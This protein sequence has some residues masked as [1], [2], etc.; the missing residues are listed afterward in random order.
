MRFADSSSSSWRGQRLLSLTPGWPAR[1]RRRLSRP[2]FMVWLTLILLGAGLWLGQR[3]SERNGIAQLNAVAAE[4]LELYAAMLEAELARHAYLPSLIAIDEEVAA[5]L[6]APGEATLRQRASLRLARIN[7]RAGALMSFIATPQGQ[8][9]SSSQAQANVAVE[10][11]VLTQALAL[12]EAP[13]HFFAANREQ[14]STEYYLVHPVRRGE[15]LQALIVVKLDL[16]P[17]EATW[18][19]LGLRSQGEKL[20]VVDEHG[21]VI[22]SSVP[23][24]KYRVLGELDEAR[25]L[26]LETSGRY[27]GAT[28]EPI[29][30]A[31][32]VLE[33]EDSSLVA[34]PR[35]DADVG[36]RGRPRQLLAQQRAAVT[37]GVRLLA[38]SDPSEVWA[39]ARYAGWGGGAV[40][41]SVGMLAL[42]LAS[43][44][45]A[46]L[47][48]S[49]ARDELQLAQVQLE[50]VVA[51]R[52]RELRSTNE[53]LKRQIAQRIQA[54]DEL[55]QAGKLAVLGQMSTGITH[56]INQPLTA[57]RALSR[58]SLQLL[59][60]GRHASVADNL[61]MIDDVVE[62]MSRITRQLKSFARKAEV[63]YAPVSLAEAV[64]NV[65]LLMEHR[66]ESEGVR[67]R[68]EV[69]EELLVHCD[70]NR[71]E[72]VLVNLLANA[73]D[74]VKDSTERWVGIS[75]ARAGDRV[76]VRVSDTG[77]GM[78]DAA[79]AR[80]FEPFFTTK[81]PGQGL[82]LGLVISTKIVHEFGGTLRAR[83]GP[84][85]AGMSF[86]FDLKAVDRDAHV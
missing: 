55:M 9:L 15:R 65:R 14:A 28:L 54:E 11:G 85:A 17:L 3:W 31:P 7:V 76:V 66:I 5:M 40:G 1:L 36:P 19:D 84:H 38:L 21:V 44:K 56:E 64:T 10:P 34:A 25:R 20:L 82:G 60:K 53:E 27:A 23:R 72:Q 32:E 12:N 81:P 37:A 63:V 41:A 69:H 16:A 73:L 86:V 39:Q 42:Y 77:T 35:D 51:E 6:K 22:M 78:D 52:T 47:Q 33:Q 48:L 59:E 18:V 80:L 29:G 57:L 74:A 58:N 8:V 4:R 79:I 2:S 45:R 46:L 24:W 13:G 26:E 75:A 71:L 68:V 70:G 61:R 49:R 50:G 43:R 83:R 62:R 30:L 67:L